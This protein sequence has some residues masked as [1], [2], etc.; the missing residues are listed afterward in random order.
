[1]MRVSTQ[2]CE[3]ELPDHWEVDLGDGPLGAIVTAHGDRHVLRVERA[4]E[5]LVSAPTLMSHVSVL[6]RQALEGYEPGEQRPVVVFGAGPALSRVV[7]TD[8]GVAGSFVQLEIIAE[9]YD[10]FMWYV[11]VSAPRGRFDNELAQSVLDSLQ[12]TFLPTNT[13]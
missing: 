7:A 13:G 5:G 11:R 9:G 12:I 8:E 1:M 6:S 4:L 3:I 2:F 10:G